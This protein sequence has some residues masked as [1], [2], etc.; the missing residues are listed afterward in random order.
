VLS[1][2]HKQVGEFTES[3]V[4]D[5]VM[6][7]GYKDS[8]AAWYAVL[9]DTRRAA[10]RARTFSALCWRPNRRPFGRVMGMSGRCLACGTRMDEGAGP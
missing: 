3:K 1:S 10:P 5:L 7:Q 9:R 2:E 6:P 4:P 8:I